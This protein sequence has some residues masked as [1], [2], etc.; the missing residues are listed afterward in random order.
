MS[1]PAIGSRGENNR[2]MISSREREYAR[3][4]HAIVCIDRLKKR[5]VRGWNNS[6]ERKSETR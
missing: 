1:S 6:T 5:G 4:R 2:G 3:I